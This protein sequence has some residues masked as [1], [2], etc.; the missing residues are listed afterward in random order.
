[1]H[2]AFILDG[3][4][5]YADR[6][7]LRKMLWHSS[8]ADNIEPI[9]DLCAKENIE[10][11]SMWALAK[12]NIEERSPEELNHIYALIQERFQKLLP[13]LLKNGIKFDTL[14]DLS[15]I[16]ENIA[17]ILRDIADQTKHG[18]KLTFVLVIWYGW[19][20]ELVRWVK[21][22]IRENAD[23]LT[24]E[25]LE[26][27]LESL[28][29]KTFREYLDC[30]SF[31]NPDLIVRTGGDVRHSGYWLYASEYS[32]YYFTDKLWPE[33]DETEFYKALSSLKSAKRNFGK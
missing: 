33:F 8:G 30:A 31:P 5:R 24:P 1:M 6:Q 32:E 18:T 17:G 22:L 27:F 13:K 10:F 9:I 12:K 29:E 11:V 21:K 3:N 26:D 2:I 28:N 14:W 16:P 15:L 20:D 4:R 23:K 7:W 25:N 19:Q